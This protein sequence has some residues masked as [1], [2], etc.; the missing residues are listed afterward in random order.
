MSSTVAILLATYQ[1]E[2]YLTTQLDSL[3]NQD[4]TDFVIY[5]QDGGSDDSTIPII[6]EYANNH[7][8]KIIYNISPHHLNALENFSSLIKKYAPNHKYI[9]FSD[10]DDLWESSKIKQTLNKM[11]ELENEKNEPICIF[12]DA[13]VVDYNLKIISPSYFEYTNLNPHQATFSKQIIQN[14]PL[15]CTM[16]IN[17]PLIDLI[18][19]I[20]ENAIMHDHWIGL[21]A[22]CFGRLYYINQSTI[23]YR[24]HSNNQ[25]GAPHYTLKFYIDKLRSKKNEIFINLD[26]SIKQAKAFK[27]FHQDKL[28]S[29]DLLVISKFIDIKKFWFFKKIFIIS[30]YKLFK[31]GFLR[32]LGL[33]IALLLIE[34]K[35]YGNE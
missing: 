22:S 7:P 1:S 4:Y 17:K 11:F 2:K 30:K 14:I 29:N 35:N 31:H 25:S 32:N 27:D 33:V 34:N 8:N 6:I 15:G 28:N 23:K 9:M 3:L 18:K 21:T 20:P 26:K 13:T 10:H 12:T 5:I 16:T 24:Q 19:T